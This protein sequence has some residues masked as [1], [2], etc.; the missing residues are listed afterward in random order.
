MSA[1]PV[2]DTLIWKHEGPI[3][4]ITL[5]SNLNLLIDGYLNYLKDVEVLLAYP[6]LFFYIGSLNIDSQV[7]VSP[8]PAGV[9]G[10]R[11]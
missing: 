11:L 1:P 10:Q 3:L 5:N 7:H 8:G 2:F 6:Q 9:L 4:T